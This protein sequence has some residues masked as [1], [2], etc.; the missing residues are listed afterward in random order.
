MVLAHKKSPGDTSPGL[1]KKTFMT[2]NKVNDSRVFPNL[3]D[4][5]HHDRAWW[6]IEA[7]RLGTHW[8]GILRLQAEIIATWRSRHDPDY[9]RVAA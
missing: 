7:R 1:S 9:E 6:R 5:V 8:P 3:P 4:H 2:E